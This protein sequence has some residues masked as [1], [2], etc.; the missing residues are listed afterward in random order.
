[1]KPGGFVGG[2]DLSPSIWQHGESFEPT[3]VF[4][5][6]LYFAEAMRTRIYALPYQ[7]F[8]IEKPDGAGSTYQFDDLVGLYGEQTVRGQIG[9]PGRV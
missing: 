5:F 9:L 3:L 1:V 8:L 6:A 2:D 4:P 7:Q